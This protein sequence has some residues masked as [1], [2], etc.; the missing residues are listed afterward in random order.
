MSTSNRSL[1]STKS[2]K[3]NCAAVAAYLLC[4]GM[5]LLLASTG[6]L[7]A[8]GDQPAEQKPRNVVAVFRLDGPITEVPADDFLEMFSAP[9]T[10]L[11]DL[12]KRVTR[13]AAD[14]EVKAVVI[15]PELYWTGTAQ[16]E[17]LLA[18]LA[19]VRIAGKEVFV[20]AD[21]LTLREYL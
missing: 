6:A 11:K 2:A 4:L 1:P 15:L 3:H 8:E 9:G 12:V 21:S 18:A 19:Q 16:T 17:E 5:A 7:A 10:S 20:H 14:R 13:A